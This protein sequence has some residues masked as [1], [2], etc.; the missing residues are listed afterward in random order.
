MCLLLSSVEAETIETPL[1]IETSVISN[2][3]SPK[4]GSGQEEDVKQLR[5]CN[6]HLWPTSLAIPQLDILKAGVN[7]GSRCM[8]L[9]SAG[10]LPSEQMR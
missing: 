7:G 4:E 3:T 9:T 2:P 5:N 1:P 8:L 6:P 10:S